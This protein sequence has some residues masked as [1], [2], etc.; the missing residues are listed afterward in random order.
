M[1]SIHVRDRLGQRGRSAA[2]VGHRA[3]TVAVSA[4]CGEDIKDPPKRQKSEAEQG[5]LNDK[6]QQ[7]EAISTWEDEGG[8]TTA[9]GRRDHAKDRK[10]ARRVS[11]KPT[12]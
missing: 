11:P 7:Q 4:A 9:P 8:T 12:G 5:R 1:T 2:R 3:L 6:Q 10:Q